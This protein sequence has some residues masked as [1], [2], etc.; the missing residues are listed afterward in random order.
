MGVCALRLL[1]SEHIWVKKCALCSVSYEESHGLSADQKQA[2]L[3]EKLRVVIPIDHVP[4][5]SKK[6]HHLKANREH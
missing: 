4:D 6:Q 2:V 5:P 1:L 3:L